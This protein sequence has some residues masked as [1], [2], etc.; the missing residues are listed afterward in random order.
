[1]ATPHLHTSVKFPSPDYQFDLNSTFCCMG[2]CFSDHLTDF[3]V[4]TKF[5]VSDNPAGITYNPWSISYT[6]SKVLDDY[7]YKMNDLIA[8]DELFHSLD[9]HGSFSNPD[10]Q[11]VITNIHTRQHTFR[12]MLLKADGMILTLGTAHVFKRN[13]S[14]LV[15]NNCHKLPTSEFSRVRLEVDEIVETLSAVFEILLKTNPH[16]KIIMSVSPVRHIRDGLIENQ[17]SKATLILAIAKLQKL[18][19]QVTYFP[20]YELVIDELRDYRFYQEDLIHP[21]DV[22]V[23]FV[24]QRFV[25]TFFNPVS[26]EYIRTIQGLNRSLNHRPLHP[27]RPSHQHFLEKT[28]QLIEALQQQYPTKNFNPERT[29]IIDQFNT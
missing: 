23:K 8:A 17:R 11:K 25:E 10:P 5:D 16:V 7:T 3:L 1:M 21:T 26:Q 15:V 29:I 4:R 27:N 2:S 14:G 19:P 13:S 22:A 18:H 28:L 12:S 24:L 20:A 6:L 9:H